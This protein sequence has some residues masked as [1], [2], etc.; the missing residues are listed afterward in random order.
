MPNERP[1][2]DGMSPSARAK[3]LYQEALGVLDQALETN[4]PERILLMD[5][6]LRLRQWARE[7]LEMKEGE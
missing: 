4:G 3:V 2:L 6:A 1:S 7:F 5:K